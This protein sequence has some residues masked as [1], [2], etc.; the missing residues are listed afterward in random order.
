MKKI[1]F[2]VVMLMALGALAG[3]GGP[4]TPDERAQWFFEHGEK[5]I[6]KSLKKQDVPDPAVEQAKTVINKHRPDV[7]KSLSSYFSSEQDVMQAIVGGKSGA[8]LV[9]LE[10]SLHQQ[11]VNALN[12]IGKMHDD[13]SNTV[14]EKTWV[15]ASSERQKRFEKH[16]K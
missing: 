6:V 10:G 16:F 8:D 7:L 3:C 9:K 15:A 11:H 12:Q 14:G 1:S 13:L 5:M 2:F 4:R